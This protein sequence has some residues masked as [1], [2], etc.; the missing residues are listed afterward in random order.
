MGVGDW[1]IIDCL[2]G[3]VAGCGYHMRIMNGKRCSTGSGSGSRSGGREIFL[4]DG[5]VDGPESKLESNFF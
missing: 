3:G 2:G 1:Y 4:T 5:N